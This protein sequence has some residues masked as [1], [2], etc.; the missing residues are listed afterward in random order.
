MRSVGIAGMSGCCEMFADDVVVSVM[1]RS[2]EAPSGNAER[3]K[4]RDGLAPNDDDSTTD[5]F[6]R[7]RIPLTHTLLH[8]ES[9]CHLVH[10]TYQRS[11]WERKKRQNMHICCCAGFSNR[12]APQKCYGTNSC[13]EIA[14]H[15]CLQ[16]SGDMPWSGCILTAWSVQLLSKKSSQQR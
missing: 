6:T 10:N 4:L 3:R 8:R 15:S 14:M 2:F 16:S 5:N 1:S 9:I 7:R 11:M 13:P 12:H